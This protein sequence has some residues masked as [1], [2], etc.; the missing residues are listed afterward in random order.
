LDEFAKNKDFRMDKSKIR[1]PKENVLLVESCSAGLMEAKMCSSIHQNLK[2]QRIF[3]IELKEH[4]FGE[5]CT[6]RPYHRSCVCN[7]L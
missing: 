3:R 4:D 5:H 1:L 7:H 2:K 6:I